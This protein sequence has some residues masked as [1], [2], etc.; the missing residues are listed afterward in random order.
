MCTCFI[1]I[2]A[3]KYSSV[4]GKKQYAETERA[5][6]RIVRQFFGD[7]SSMKTSIVGVSIVPMVRDSGGGCERSYH[8]H[9]PPGG[10]HHRHGH[11]HDDPRPPS[12]C[13]G[14]GRPPLAPGARADDAPA[15]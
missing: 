5:H 6:A 2:L 4:W 9:G 8:I 12:Q 14:Y 13:L 7:A 11:A 15:H 1:I 10:L 3:R